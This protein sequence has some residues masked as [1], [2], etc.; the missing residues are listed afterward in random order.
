MGCAMNVAWTG[1]RP[2]LFPEPEIIAAAIVMRAGELRH[3]LGAVL[4]FHC[5]G[6]RGVD[7][8]AA[9]AAVRLGVPLHLYLPLP[10]SR[11]AADWADDDRRVLEQSWAS[12]VERVVVDPAGTMGPDAYTLR[13][14][15]LAEHCDLLIA[16]WT[17]RGGGGTAETIE[18]ARGLGRQIAEHH[19]PPSGWVPQAGERGV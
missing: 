15:L 9:T 13:N 18:I 1:H 19:F 14:R 7:T 11:F 2:E 10:I 17:G 16:M 4:A 5:G 6:Q 12:A 8:W 3:E